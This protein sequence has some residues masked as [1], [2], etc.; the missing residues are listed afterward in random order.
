MKLSKNEIIAYE[1]HKQAHGEGHLN[2]LMDQ[3]IEEC[4]ELQ[5]A[6]MHLRRGRISTEQVACE[7]ADVIFCIK[8]LMMTLC[9]DVAV[10][11]LIENNAENLSQR[12]DHIIKDNAEKGGLD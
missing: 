8:F 4:A 5:T 6:L 3:T 2:R 9:M 11:T 7:S 1:K 12:L 10:D